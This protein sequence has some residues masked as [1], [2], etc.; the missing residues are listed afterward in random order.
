[1][2]AWLVCLETGSPKSMDGPDWPGIPFV[3]QAAPRLSDSLA[4]S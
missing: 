1:M 3:G 2:L 4:A